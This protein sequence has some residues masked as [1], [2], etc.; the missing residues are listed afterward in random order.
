MPQD[1]YFRRAI[2]WMYGDDAYLQNLPTKDL[3]N[4]HINELLGRHPYHPYDPDMKADNPCYKFNTLFHECME[5]DHVNGYE[6]YQKHVACYFPYKVDLMKCIAT[7]KRR[8]RM[9]MEALEAKGPKS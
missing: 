7:E 8:H 5:A 1:T 4:K 2:D 3:G 6:L 9:E